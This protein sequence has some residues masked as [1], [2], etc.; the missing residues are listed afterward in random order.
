MAM[1]VTIPELEHVR[2][3]TLWDING[4]VFLGFP[5]VD[6]NFKIRMRRN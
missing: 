5:E 6:F 1:Y 4:S 3:K 2:F